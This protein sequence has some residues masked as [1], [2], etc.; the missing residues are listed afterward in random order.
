MLARWLWGGFVSVALIALGWIGCASDAAQDGN[1]G[2]ADRCE[3]ICRK[4][5]AANCPASAGMDSCMSRCTALENSSKCAQLAEAL[6]SCQLASEAQ[7]TGGLSPSAA[8]EESPGLGPLVCCSGG[9]GTPT[10][11]ACKALEFQLSSC[12]SSGYEGGLSFC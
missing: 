12:E 5:E 11:P 3:T 10:F 6:L 7:C 9:A 2:S 4:A 1:Q 8:Q